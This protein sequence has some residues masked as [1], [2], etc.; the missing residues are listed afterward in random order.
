MAPHFLITIDVEGDNVW[1]RPRQAETG[2]AAYMPRFQALCEQYGLR[3]TY[4]TN[5]EMAMS[6]I[7]RDFARD[8]VQR[9]V[10]EIGMH[11][12]AWDTPPFEP[13]TDDDSR[14][15]PYLI[16]Y[17]ESTIRKKVRAMTDTLES[18]VGTKM[19]SHRAGR[20]A[21][22]ASYAKA[23]VDCGYVADCSVTPHVS[24][25]GKPGAPDGPGGSDYSRAPEEPYFVDLADVVR[26]GNSP[27]L[28]VPMTI[29][30]SMKPVRSMLS[31]LKGR[32]R[33]AVDRLLPPIQWLRPNGRNVDSMLEIIRVKKAAG[34][35]HIEF[36]LHSSEF[37]P[38]G[39]PTFKTADA[40][41]RLYADMEQVFAATRG[42]IPSTVS[43]FRAA[44]VS[45]AVH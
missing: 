21:F 34:A 4:L 22:N 29:V 20:W 42:L 12:H 36:M 39:S 24:W 32:A 33:A 43:E 27:L 13:L 38:G 25:R 37:M 19:L 8:V 31:G 2:N 16:D 44:F 26:P 6:P 5:H 15:Q 7:Y 35:T 41:E 18:M 3:P 14:H 1:A 9:N 23:L 28:E 11:L 30:A 10:G 40:I 45:G 17:P